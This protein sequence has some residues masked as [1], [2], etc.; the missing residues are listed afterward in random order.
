MSLPVITRA[1]ASALIFSGAALCSITSPGRAQTNPTIRL[2]VL[3]NENAAEAYYA[4]DM[5][6]F[7]KVGIDAD[8]QQMQGTSLVVAAMASSAIDI[9]YVT[10]DVL[11]TIHQKNIPIV[12]IAPATEYLFPG[13]ARISAIV[14]PANSTVHQAKDLNGKIIATPALHSLGDDATR[15][16][17]DRNGGDSSTVKFVEIPFPAM[18]AALDAG[19]IDAAFVAEPFV[20]VAMK[21]G[22]VLADCF[23]AISKHFLIAAWCTTPQWA[24]DHPDL[25]NRFASVMLHTAIWANKNQTKSGELLAKYTK[26][27]PSVIA[28]MA[29]VRY[30]EQM[31]PALMQPLIDVSAKYNK[32]SAFPAQEVIYAHPR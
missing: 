22:R 19:R 27:D 29:R 7:Q 32:F 8:I 13:T 9:G 25:V 26:V 18:P 14:L 30:A 5:G 15:V 6:F 3:P 4:K 17:I 11:A 24:K 1:R 12:V 10:I 31:L 23:E 20:S 16:W 21:T 2:A 28:T